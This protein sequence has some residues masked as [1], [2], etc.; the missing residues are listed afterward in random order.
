MAPISLKPFLTYGGTASS[1][2]SSCLT[3][4]ASGRAWLLSDLSPADTHW[5]HMLP[6]ESFCHFSSWF[7]ADSPT[8]SLVTGSAGTLYVILLYSDHKDNYLFNYEF[9]ICA[10]YSSP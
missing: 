6:L 2:L 3:C 4:P 5:A 8:L 1:L 9:N 10:P 7:P